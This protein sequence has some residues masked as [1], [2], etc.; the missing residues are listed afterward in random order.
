MKVFANTNPA[1]G[2]PTLTPF[3]SLTGRKMSLE[4]A[5]QTLLVQSPSIPNT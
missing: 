1:G 5:Q 2:G 3:V 4:G